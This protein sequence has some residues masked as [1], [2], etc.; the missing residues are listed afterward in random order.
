MLGIKRHT[1]HLEQYDEQWSVLFKKTKSEIRQI[2]GSNSIDIQHI[3]STAIK[4]ITAKPILDIA[5][6]VHELSAINVNEMEHFGYIHKGEAG[7][8]GRSFF[9]KYRNK[10]ISTHHIH[11][12]ESI[13]Q[14]LLA[15]ISF[16]N[17]LITHPEYAKQYNDLKLQLAE[18]YFDNRAKY[19]SEKSIFINMILQLARLSP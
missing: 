2:L 16:R 4:G 13:N 15:S 12:Y 19:T 5:V 8:P 14:N 9:A 1:V 10:D 6:I 7:V 3:G 17:F 11:C 18:R